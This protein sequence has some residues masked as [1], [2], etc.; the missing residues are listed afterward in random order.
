MVWT[1]HK[2][3]LELS[4]QETEGLKKAI[5]GPEFHPWKTSS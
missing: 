2:A 1:R 4:R 3:S 5:P